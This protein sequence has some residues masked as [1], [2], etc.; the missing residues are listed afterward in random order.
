MLPFR[1]IRGRLVA[2]RVEDGSLRVVGGCLSV[3]AA[4]LTGRVGRPIRPDGRWLAIEDV[5]EP[6][7]RVDRYL[8][9]LKIAGWFDRIAGVLVG[10]FHT[11]RA[12]QQ[13]AVL[14]LLRFHLLPARGLPIVATKD[15]GHVWPMSPLPI[16][17][18]LRIWRRGNSVTIGD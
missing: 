2:G 9:A 12:S 15:F 4:V 10:D 16:N 7:Y 18:P 3:L 13:P 11:G 14:E 1:P 6:P 8:A 5:N 17:R